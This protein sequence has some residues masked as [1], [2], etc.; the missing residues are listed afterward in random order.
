VLHVAAAMALSTPAPARSPAAAAAKHAI[1]ILINGNPLPIDPPPRFENGVLFVPVQRTLAAL[2]LP[3]ERTGKAI[4]TQAG[5]KNV[6]LEVGSRFAEV[7]GNRV[8]LDAPSTEVRGTLYAPLRFFTDVLGAQADFD[9]R[10]NTVTIVAQLIGRTEFGLVSTGNG[11]TRSGTVAAV[12]VL[13]EPPTLTLGY[14]TGPKTI[15]IAPNAIVEMEDVNADVT[16]PGELGDVRPGDYARVEMRKDGRVTRVVDAFG[17][18]NGRIVAVAGNQ[19]VMADGQVV[20]AGRTTEVALN[21][22]A[23]SFADLRAGDVVTVRYNVESN[24]VREVLA[25]RST[26][27]EPGSSA[28]AVTADATRPLRAGE[29]VTVRLHGPSGGAATFDIGS[30]V[31]DLAMHETAPGEYVGSYTISQGANFAQAAV[32]GRLSQRGGGSVEAEAPQTLS[33]SSTPPG[34]VDFAPD[35]GTT[36]NNDR[37]AIYA[38]FASDAVAVNPSSAAIWINGHDVT[39]DSVRTPQ[40]IQY[41]PAYAYPDGLVRVTVRVADEAGNATTKS[42]TFTIRTH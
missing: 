41:V 37:P 21:G 36:V 18:Y 35:T 33:A 5:S 27:G 8:S 29:S 3:F 16:T 10:T 34:I 7:D 1:T 19:F 2:G 20:G 13:S 22:K 32:I 6:T 31:S 4:S 17:S 9:R 30:Y 26:I 38:T 14:D 40:F 11:F 28:V 23:A 12:D 25:S 15:S 24:E 42:W 39:S